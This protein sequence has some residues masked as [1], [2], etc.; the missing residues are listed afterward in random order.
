VSRRLY[1]LGVDTS[2]S[3]VNRLFPAWAEL[4]GVAG[5]ELVG[6][7]A[8]QGAP[9]DRIR[10]MVETV[11]QDEQAAGALVTT[12][13]VAVYE[14]ARDL[15]AAIDGDAERLGEVGCMVRRDARLRGI[16][17]DHESSGIPLRLIT[18]GLPW[19]RD[20][21]LFGAGGAGRAIAFHLARH[22]RPRRMIV[23]D[24]SADRLAATRAVVE[25]EMGTAERNVELLQSLGEGALV[26]N[27]T[28]LGK[29]RPGSPLPDTA[30]FPKDAVAW[31]LN[32]RGDLRFLEQA[33]AQ[34]VRIEDGWVYFVAGW[35]TVMSHVYGFPL[36]PELLDD[37][38]CAARR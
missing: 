37:A 35:M 6:L 13:K 11:A 26:V 4:C 2:A 24:T 21:L 18:G 15:L 20:V 36:T 30:I 10:E 22:H 27:A 8:P 9:R 14:G 5:A 16:A 38:L 23:T 31:D 3:A 29:D 28:G 17:I 33:R 12:H 34:R 1:F 19:Q 7:D 32:Y 25:V